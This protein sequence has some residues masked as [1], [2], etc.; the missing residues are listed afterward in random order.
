MTPSAR[1]GYAASATGA[2]ATSMIPRTPR[3][4]AISASVNQNRIGP[5]LRGSRRSW[6]GRGAGRPPYVAGRRTAG[7]VRGRRTARRQGRPRS[8]YC[9]RRRACTAGGRRDPA[10]R[11]PGRCARG[12]PATA[13]VPAEP[14]ERDQAD[15]GERPREPVGAPRVADQR[16]RGDH[17]EHDQ[18]HGA[19]LSSS[20]TGA[21]SVPSSGTSS[22]QAPYR[23][24]PAPPKNASTTN[25]TRRMIGSM[26]RWR[27]R[28]PATPAT[29]R[30]WS[31]R[32][33][34]PRSRISSRVTRG[35]R[36]RCP[37]GRAR[38]S[39]RWCRRHVSSVARARRSQH[40]R[41]RP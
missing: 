14:D 39:F 38:R 5:R 4:S 26:S 3:P 34:R 19:A 20:V 12:P 28:P 2:P 37:G 11:R 8:A 13:A 10:G 7:G 35:P 16:E 41:G 31:E 40:H 30:S 6:S 9:R 29:L 24:R 15:D 25:A 32:R 27:A 23:I 21:S 1:A 17:A 18:R 33:S 36:R 22:Q